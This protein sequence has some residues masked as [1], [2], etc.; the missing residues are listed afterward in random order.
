[1]ANRAHALLIAMALILAARGHAHA[2]EIKV[3]VLDSS[4]ILRTTNEGKK[5]TDTLN[6]YIALRQKV[7]EG[8]AADVKKLEE[9][10]AAQST[11]ITAQAKQEKENAARMRITAYQQKTQQ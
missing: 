1:M 11:A 5:M 2:A 4:Q 9:E 10:L 6:E 3:A 8:D 7:L